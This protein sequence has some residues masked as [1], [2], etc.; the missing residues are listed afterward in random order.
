M[1][2]PGINRCFGIPAHSLQN[3]NQTAHESR[4][5]PSREIRS[6]YVVSPLFSDQP[7]TRSRRSPDLFRLPL[8][9]MY[10]HFHPRSPNTP[11]NRQRVATP[12][13]KHPALNGRVLKNK[14]PC[15]PQAGPQSSPVL[16]WLGREAL[17]C[18]AFAFV[19]QALLPVARSL[20]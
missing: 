5:F 10:T 13:H 19:A 4:H 20:V 12:K 14:K 11:K 2:V 6:H 3:H 18:D 15:G 17:A 7:M 9:P 1:A 8:P 16:A